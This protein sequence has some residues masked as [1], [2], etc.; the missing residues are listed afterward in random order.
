VAAE[1]FFEKGNFERYLKPTTP[2][3]PRAGHPDTVRRTLEL[4]ESEQKKAEGVPN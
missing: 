1:R 2:E 3:K 4:M